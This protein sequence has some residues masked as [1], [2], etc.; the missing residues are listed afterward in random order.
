[1]MKHHFVHIAHNVAKE[2]YLLS[3]FIF[4]ITHDSL[5]GRHNGHSIVG[6]VISELQIV[7][8]TT[9]IVRE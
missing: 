6:R 2:D 1:M 7:T 3:P 5:S 9:R 8:V 4:K